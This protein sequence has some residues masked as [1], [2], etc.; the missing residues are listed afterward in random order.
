MKYVISGASGFIGSALSKR[1]SSMGETVVELSRGDFTPENEMIL[2]SKLKGADIVINLAGATINR[3]W[4]KHNKAEILESRIGTTDKIVNT[5]NALEHKPALFISTS[6]IGLYPSFGCFRDI[7]DIYAKGFLADVCRKWEDSA[8]NISAEVRLVITRLA[9]VLSNDGGIL[10]PLTKLFRHHIGGR[11]GNGTQVFCWIILNDLLNIY[12]HIITN[13]SITGA[14]NC[15]A[16][17]STDNRTLTKSL[18]SKINIAAPWIIPKFMLRLF[19]GESAIILT[20]GEEAIPYKLN[21]SGFTFT[22]HNIND[23]LEELY[24]KPLEIISNPT[25]INI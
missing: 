12:T 22:S 7:S 25:I 13:K 2:F 9:P 16:P 23:A 5:I 10:P 18:A 15:A 3:R 14:V 6:A 8:K 4:T 20:K 21:E 19:M 24:D 11:I 17:E 1:L